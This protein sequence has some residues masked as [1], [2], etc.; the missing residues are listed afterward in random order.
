MTSVD[1]VGGGGHRVDALSGG[2]GRV[3]EREVERAIYR[4]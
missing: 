3:G 1:A 4:G 2:G